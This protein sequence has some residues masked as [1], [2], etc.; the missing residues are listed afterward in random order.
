[1]ATSYQ[2][3]RRLNKTGSVIDFVPDF[4]PWFDTIC[5]CNDGSLKICTNKNYKNEAKPD[6]TKE[7]N[8]Q[9]ADRPS[10]G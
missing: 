9:E 5:V 2:E 6:Q 10:R 3:Q 1:M 8:S 7:W 4:E